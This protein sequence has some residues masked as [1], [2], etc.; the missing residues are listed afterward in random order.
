MEI[1]NMPH[2]SWMDQ[3][4]WYLY[5]MEFYPATKKDE[6]LSFGG[7]W[8]KLKNIVISDISQV[9]KAKRDIFSLICAI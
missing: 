5:T 6:I 3:E 1:A 8:M 9:Q 2:Y 7:K 4:M